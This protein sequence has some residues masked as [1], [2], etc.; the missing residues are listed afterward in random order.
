MEAAASK[1][2]Q[3]AAIL[4]LQN[5]FRRKQQAQAWSKLLRDL[6]KLREGFMDEAARDAGAGDNP[7]YSDVMLI[8]REKLRNEPRVVQALDEAW[9]SLLPPN[10]TTLSKKMYYTM[11]RK[12]Y[13]AALVADAE[14]TAAFELGYFFSGLELL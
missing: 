2:I 9:A 5:Y 3:E 11:S 6:P 4:R 8:Q 13:L 1:E 7:L 10:C 12:L 14:D